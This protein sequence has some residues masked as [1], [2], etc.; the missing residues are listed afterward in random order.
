[1]K[2]ESVCSFRQCY[3]LLAIK[4]FKINS[5]QAFKNCFS[6]WV[7]IN[8]VG[9]TGL[10]SLC[11]FISH[12]HALRIRLGSSSVMHFISGKSGRHFHCYFPRPIE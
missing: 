3:Q 9:N 8:E 12:F 6:E 10:F 4:S 1:M 2:F 5:N 7:L 11:K